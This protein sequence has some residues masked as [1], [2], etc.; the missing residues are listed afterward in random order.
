MSRLFYRRACSCGWG[1]AYP[2]ICL[3]IFIVST[4]TVQHP[5][6]QVDHLLLVIGKAVGV[7]L[8]ADGRVFGRALLVAFQHPFQR[9]VGAQ[10]IVPRFGRDAAQRGDGVDSMTPASLRAIRRGLGVR[11]PSRSR[12]PG[13]S[14][15][16]RA[17]GYGAT[18]S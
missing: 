6:Q 17:S 18:C 10:P 7:E 13:R 8:L 15:S 9:G 12:R 2:G 1:S 14:L 3:M 16:S 4:L 5:A 11:R